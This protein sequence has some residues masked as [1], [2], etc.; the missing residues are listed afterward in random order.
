MSNQ[1][2]LSASAARV[3]SERVSRLILHRCVH[4]PSVSRSLVMLMNKMPKMTWSSTRAK[5]LTDCPRKYAHQHV[6]GQ[7]GH[8]NGRRSDN[9][10]VAQAWSLG[11]RRKGGDLA[12]RAARSTMNW[13]L[14]LWH[15]GEDSSTARIMMKVESA[16]HKELRSAAGAGEKVN[17]D[18]LLILVAEASRQVTEMSKA[19]LLRQLRQ[20]EGIHEWLRLDQLQPLYMGNLRAYIAPSLII[21]IG[22]TWS[23]VK[24]AMR[25]PLRVPSP[26]GR[27]EAHAMVLWAKQQNGLPENPNLYSVVRLAWLGRSWQCWQEKGSEVRA[28]TARR[29]LSHDAR[30]FSQMQ[31]VKSPS[32]SGQSA[33]DDALRSVDRT[34]E[35]RHCRNCGYR[36]VCPGSVTVKGRSRKEAENFAGLS[37]QR[38]RTRSIRTAAGSL[39]LVTPLARSTPSAPNSIAVATSS[40]LLTPAPQR[41]RT[42]ESTA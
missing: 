13:L 16:L 17:S 23:L 2:L 28:E 21:R 27:I 41:T 10:V 4:G 34:V 30:E 11:Q 31:K 8:P 29:L 18:R 12:M 3:M 22:G 26:L 20:R 36:R 5:T 33:I 25:A 9:P 32:D 19:P 39:D 42:V 6:I 24:I 7:G 35:K 37:V 15:R 14:D 40:P 1:L 38:S